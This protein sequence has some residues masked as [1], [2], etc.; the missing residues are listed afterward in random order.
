MIRIT[1]K[2]RKRK[3]KFVLLESNSGPFYMHTVFSRYGTWVDKWKANG[4]MICRPELTEPGSYK[5]S[6]LVSGEGGRSKPS[7]EVTYVDASETLYQYQ[8]HAGRTILHLTKPPITTH[9]ITPQH[10]FKPHPYHI[11]SHHIDITRYY[12]HTQT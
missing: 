2:Q 12:H 7:D 9:Y 3:L 6:Y 11:T 5:V 1:R 4:Y 8:A 10:H